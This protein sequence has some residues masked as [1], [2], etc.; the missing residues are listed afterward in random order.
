MRGVFADADQPEKLE[1][2]CRY[3]TRPAVS[4]KRLSLTSTGNVRYELKTPY[5][6]GTV[7]GIRELSDYLGMFSSS[8]PGWKAEIKKHDEIGHIIRVTV[9]FN[10]PGPDGS[11]QEQLGQHFVEQDGDV[12]SRLVGFAG[13]GEL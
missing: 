9:S 10:G 5:N 2:L 11:N 7:N 13:I 1:R 6:D 8:A 4:E 12:L 3:I